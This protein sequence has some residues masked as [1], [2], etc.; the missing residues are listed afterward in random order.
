MKFKPGIF[1]LLFIS[2]SV[3]A[4]EDF[5]STTKINVGN[6]LP[7]FSLTGLDGK[8]LSSIELKGKV[9]LINFWATWCG[10]CKREMP[11][12]QSELFNKI[13]SK[14]F[15]MAA[16]SRGEET[17]I[18]KKF[19]ELNKYTF[20]IY[21][22]KETKVYSLFATKFIPRNFVVGKE[23]KIIWATMGYVEK[24]FNEMIEVIKKELAR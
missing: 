21:V 9:T 1:V 22:D 13:K 6:P 14:N 16:I 3:F 24:E 18:V 12:M 10:P 11:L 19:I 17:E 5:K 23:G 2:V 20:P 8:T 7:E 4:Q 15:V